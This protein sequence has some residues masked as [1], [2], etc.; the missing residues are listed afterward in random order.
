MSCVIVI[1]VAP[2]DF[3]QLT[4]SSL[5][6]SVVIGSSPLVGS[7]KNNTSGSDAIVRAIATRL[8]MPPESSLG[9]SSAVRA[10]SSTESRHCKARCLASRL[11]VP[12]CRR[13]KATFCQTFMLSNKAPPWKTIPI[14][15]RNAS[16]SSL[17]SE[18]P[19]MRISPRSGVSNPKIHLTSTDF[20]SPERPTIAIDSPRSISRSMPWRTFF[21][22]KDLS[23]P[24]TEIFAGVSSE[25]TAA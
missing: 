8:R 22:S 10:G 17:A 3:V 13:R 7:S 1:A 14:V 6:K 5:I 20:P 11:P 23:K 18:C 4:I 16:P 24:R 15:E 12:C 19:S 9:S 2:S 21:P 25:L